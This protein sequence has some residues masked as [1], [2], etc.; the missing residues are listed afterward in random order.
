MVPNLCDNFLGIM[1]YK[2]ALTLPKQKCVFKGLQYKYF[3]NT[4]DKMRHCLRQAI[5]PFPTV[6][7]DPSE[8]LSTVFIK[9]RIV[10]LSSANTFNLEEAKIKICCM[11][12]S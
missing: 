8:E 12:M 9:F 3:E 6:F 10:E 11:G 4:V 7:L 2:A 1:H 5:S